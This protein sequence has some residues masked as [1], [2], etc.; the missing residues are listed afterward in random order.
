MAKLSLNKPSL[1]KTSKQKS[2]S[3]HGGPFAFDLG[4]A[5]Q[6]SLGK[7][8]LTEAGKKLFGAVFRKVGR[9]RLSGRRRMKEYF[10]PERPNLPQVSFRFLYI[11]K[12]E[13]HVLGVGAR[14]RREM[15]IG[16]QPDTFVAAPAV[17]A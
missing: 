17:E 11:E 10:R 15:L 8:L 5:D 6:R 14:I 3:P 16:E 9:H 2:Q 1:N 7:E 13:K 4:T 12:L